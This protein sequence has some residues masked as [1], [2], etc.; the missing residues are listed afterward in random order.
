MRQPRSVD[1]DGF[2]AVVTEVEVDAAFGLGQPHMD[3]LLHALEH[4]ASRTT[5]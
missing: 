2:P 3:G 5:W 1:F 4:R